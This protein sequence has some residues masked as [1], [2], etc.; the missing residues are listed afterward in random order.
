MA[1]KKPEGTVSHQIFLSTELHKRVT[2]LAEYG[3][4]DSLIVEC[5]T[6]AIEPRWKRWLKKENAKVQD[7]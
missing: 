2:T 7:R 4:A 5:V 3:K 1:K 6:E